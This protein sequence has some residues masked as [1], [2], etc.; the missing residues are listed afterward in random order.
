MAILA[1]GR[2]ASVAGV[3]C[4]AAQSFTI[5]FTGLSGSGKSTLAERVREDLVGRSLAVEWLD[6]SRIRRELNRDLGFSREDIEHNLRRIG[7]ECLLLNRNGVIAIASAI[8]P[9]REV[10]DALRQQIGRF[11]EV[12]CRSPLEV[13][14]RRDEHK[15]YERAQRGEIKNVAG[16]DAPYEE[17]LKPEVVVETDREDIATCVRKITHTAEILGYLAPHESS[18]YTPQEEDLIKQRL[19][20]LGYI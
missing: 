18:L 10:R 5:W 13:L 11:I 20:D 3:Q 2:A 1:M 19:R 16:I 8:S 15:L 17:P 7:Y 4:M 9:Y 14:A 12:Y 6:S